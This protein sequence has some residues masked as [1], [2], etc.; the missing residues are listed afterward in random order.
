M[1]DQRFYWGTIRKSVVAFGNMFN[2]LTI[3]RKDSSGNSI[4]IQRVPL[5]YSPKQKFI[6]RLNQQPEID[7]NNFQVILPRMGFEMVAIDYDPNRKISPIQQTRALSG[8]T[9]ATTQYAPTPYNLTMYL[10]IY[11]RNQ[12]DGLQIIE[13]ILPYFN[14]DYNLTLKAIPDLNIQNDLPILL[15]SIGFEDDYEGDLTTRRSIIWTLGFVMKLNFYGPVSKQ[16][17]IK[18]VI[19]N[20]FNNKDLTSQQQKI[21]VETDPTSANVSDSYS[22][23]E[24]FEDF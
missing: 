14:P 17:I 12:D 9:T 3:E 2:N 8:S 18:K 5:S 16:G 23:L 11:S 1:L 6:S 22:Y 21:T 20:T 4:G 10:Y 7:K 15:N 19:A 24:I 13:Q